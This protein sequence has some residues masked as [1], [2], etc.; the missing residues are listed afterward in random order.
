M[1][2]KDLFD[3]FF[4][5]QI[6][7]EQF[8]EK[9]FTDVFPSEE[10]ILAKINNA[11]ANK[12]SL[13]IEESLLLLYSGY[14]RSEVLT[15]KLTE[16]LA[17]PWHI[18]HEDIALYLQSLADP[19]TV[20][21]LYHASTMQFDYLDYDDTYQFAR[22]CIKAISQINDANA[23]RKL[24]L[25]ASNDIVQISNYAK[26]EL[27]YKGVLMP[28]D[29]AYGKTI[30]IPNTKKSQKRTFVLLAIVILLAI[31]CYLFK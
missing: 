22:K 21:S 23:I 12:D 29:P 18:K 5:K 8:I 11:I 25:L 7:G 4:T 19:K 17:C 13:A 16:L 30:V 15:E 14:F 31:L 3:L 2:E 26:K 9:Y 20:N 24:W 6:S 10:Y 28:Q 1:G 27:C